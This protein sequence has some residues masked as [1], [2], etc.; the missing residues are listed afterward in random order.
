MPISMDSLTSGQDPYTVTGSLENGGF[1]TTEM[2][3]DHSTDAF[4]TAAGDAMG[5]SDFLTLLTTQLKYQDPLEPQDNGE[6]VAQLAQFSQLEATSSQ[7]ESLES[8]KSSFE[9]SLN[10]QNS[11]ALSMSNS[12]AVTLIG[13]EVRLRQQA[14][15]WLG[16]G[17]AEFNVHLG[18]RKSVTAAVVD[19]DGAIVKE[20]TID[21]KDATNAGSFSWDGTNVNG[22]A[23]GPGEYSL[24]IEGQEDDPSLYCF[25]ED[26]VEGVRY[27]GNGPVVK[28]SG[29]ELPIGN[30]LEVNPEVGN[31]SADALDMTMG[32]ALSLVGKEVRYSDSGTSFATQV[33]GVRQYNIDFAGSSTAR[34]VVRD[35]EG[36]IAFQY[37]VRDEN[38]NGVED[39]DIPMGDINGTGGKYTVSIENNSNAYF[40]KEGP[41]S[42]VIPT[43]YGI[44]L[45]V[46]GMEISSKDIL[47]VST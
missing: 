14:F 19:E 7:S 26:S 47:E 36:N 8:L 24:H 16:S 37:D 45:K 22:Q 12:T 6:F 40:Y 46:D 5:K 41:I 13:K 38:G 21:K 27:T 23:M 3:G 33:D 31:A 39:I 42:G 11:S 30:I 44:K 15:D 18:E 25:V 29:K 4:S 32:Q 2:T 1:T 43:G 10:I 9:N 28:V 17:N 20:F 34:V 35:G